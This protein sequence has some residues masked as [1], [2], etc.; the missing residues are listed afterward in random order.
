MGR[1]HGSAVGEERRVSMRS[2]VGMEEREEEHCTS[3]GWEEEKGV[4]S[5]EFIYCL[6]IEFQFA[7]LALTSQLCSDSHSVSTSLP[8]DSG[9]GRRLKN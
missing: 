6:N 1:G 3:M 8:A 2:V 9:L 7:K 4:V 5:V